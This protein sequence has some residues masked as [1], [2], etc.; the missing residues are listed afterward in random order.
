MQILD[1]KKKAPKWLQNWIW[2]GLGLR[3]GGI[4]DGLG[5]LLGTFGRFLSKQ[6]LMTGRGRSQMGSKRPFGA[7][8][9]RFWRVLG[10][11][12]VDFGSIWAG[13]WKI[14]QALSVVPAGQVA[15]V[16]Q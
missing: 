6:P 15:T 12:G 16:G 10:R 8:L 11:F 3:L 7:I 14:S 2:E 4:W 13:F 9:D 5:G 1:V